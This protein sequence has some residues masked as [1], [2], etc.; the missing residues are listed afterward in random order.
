MGTKLGNLQIR[1]ASVEEVSA[2]LPKALV[3]QWA[4]G[5]VSV[6]H[7]DFQW[8]TVEREGKKLSRKLPGA[9]VLAAALFD[10]DVVSFELFQAGKRL[11]AHLLNPYEEQNILGKPGVFCEALGLPAEDEKRLKVLWKKG[12]ACEQLEMTALL[13]GLPLWAD[14]ECLPEKKVV[15]DIAAVDAWITERPDPP[16][17][18]SVSKAEVIQ[19]L[20]GLTVDSSCC[21]LVRAPG[22]FCQVFA[23]GETEI[24]GG[25]E[26]IQLWAPAADGTLHCAVKMTIADN[27]RCHIQYYFS[28]KRILAAVN[29][30]H[31]EPIPN[32]PGAFQGKSDST[33]LIFDS[34]KRFPL[35]LLLSK[36]M[37][38]C[39]PTADGG[40][41]TFISDQEK[42]GR[43]LRYGPEGKRVYEKT[44]GP[45]GHSIA[46]TQDRLYTLRVENG[47]DPT[48]QD[49]FHFFCYDG[50]GNLCGEQDLPWNTE[51]MA[52][53]R[54]G[55][56]WL[57]ENLG[58]SI[59]HLDKDLNILSRSS[60]LTSE[61]DYHVLDM[62]LSKDKE[63]VFLTSFKKGIFLLD[64]KDLSILQAKM[65][66]DTVYGAAI[67]G[68][69]RFWAGVSES[70]LE[71]Y[72]RNLQT[73]SR[74]R[75]KG[76]IM[77][78]CRNDQGDLMAY[79]HD[80]KRNIFRVYRIA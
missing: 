56:L 47:T 2:L 33:Y 46:M 13:L 12:D 16:K 23:L 76:S 74:H 66:R 1:G 6:Y 43:L 48:G 42:S 36:E 65:T 8:G 22:C 79:T 57:G 78:L 53:D 50:E 63:T 58:R 73:I 29:N 15:R 18:K 24:W 45:C 19:E 51:L 9:V 55:G 39:I 67:D 14:A 64:A 20:Q 34:D 54:E 5:F 44:I 72:D 11:T 38:D 61:R 35:P 71:A 75:L 41:W 10:D 27:R 59:F 68:Q 31:N 4:E 25:Q 30:R 69:G 49:S 28:P 17:I 60:V 7:E 40:I 21:S 37:C 26:E 70:T 80:R 62:D 77:T 32:Y 3:G 52:L